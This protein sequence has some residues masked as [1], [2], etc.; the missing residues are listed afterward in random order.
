MNV[1]LV[2]PYRG[3]IFEYS[4]V[5]IQPLGVSYIGAALK[6][7]GHNIQIE[8]LENSDSLPDIDGADVVGI[9]CN[10]VQFKSGLRVAKSAKEQGKIVIMG[11]PHPTSS[12]DEALK[13]GVVDYVV[14]AEGEAT[15]VELLEGLKYGK[16]FNPKKVLGISYIDKGTD[17]IVHNPNRPY[18]ENLD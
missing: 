14:R 13:S 6:K 9:S 12:P 11:G 16:H 4:G 5:K 17:S 3:A 10:A 18:I 15:A 2:S 8:L 1:V 7:A